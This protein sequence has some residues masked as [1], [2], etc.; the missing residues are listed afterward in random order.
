VRLGDEVTLELPRRR[1]AAG[2][3][4]VR[5]RTE[6]VALNENPFR[7]FA[8]V[9]RSQAA[10]LGLAGQAN[11][12]AVLPAGSSASAQLRRRLF[13]VRGVVSVQ[14]VTD[15]AKLLD[16]RMD[17]FVGVLRVVQAIALALALLIAFNSAAIAFEERRREYA[18]MFAFGMAPGRVL[19]MSLLEGALAGAVA[20]AAG[21]ALGVAVVGWVV[22]RVTPE[23]FPELGVPVAL[24]GSTVATAAMLGVAAVALAPLLTVRKLNRMDVP[25]ALRIVE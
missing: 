16:E 21:L 7:T 9:D 15:N 22:N 4:T 8:Y 5:L 12:L 2:F 3:D 24:S 13:E 20:T 14:G 17:D 18:T 11:Q 19:R 10:K 25:S 6:V 1:G 23:T